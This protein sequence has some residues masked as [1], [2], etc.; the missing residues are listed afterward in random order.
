MPT[1]LISSSAAPEKHIATGLADQLQQQGI[2][3]F[4]PSQACARLEASKSFA[5]KIMQQANIPTAAWQ[6][7]ERA[8]S[9]HAAAMQLLR[10][11]GGVVLKADGL[12]SGKGVHVCRTEA[13]S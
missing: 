7:V 13:G 2:A 4:A 12:A 5:K 3:V 1:T 9:C 8:D 11:K 10:R 6:A